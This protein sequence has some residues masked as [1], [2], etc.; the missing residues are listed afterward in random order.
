[1]LA[2]VHHLESKATDDELELLYVLM[3]AKLLAR[4]QREANQ[5]TVKRYPLFARAAPPLA[6]DFRLLLEVTEY[7]AAKREAAD[8]EP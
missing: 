5:I 2:A 7:H 1:M 4:A 6:A 3:A 8:L